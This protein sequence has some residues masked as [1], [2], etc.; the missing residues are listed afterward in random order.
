MKRF[1]GKE[2]AAE[3]R[4]NAAS[5]RRAALARG[6]AQNLDLSLLEP[7]G[8]SNIRQL[9]ALSNNNHNGHLNNSYETIDNKFTGKN[10]VYANK[11]LESKVASITYKITPA[12]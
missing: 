8:N 2:K 5:N 9:L 3:L 11:Q 4:E 12:A 10:P 6:Y 7:Q 1:Y